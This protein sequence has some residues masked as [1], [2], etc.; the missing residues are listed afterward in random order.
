VSGHGCAPRLIEKF[1]RG[2]DAGALDAACLKR[3][4]RPLFALP[5]GARP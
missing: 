5:A 1:I 2:A 3:I 4:P